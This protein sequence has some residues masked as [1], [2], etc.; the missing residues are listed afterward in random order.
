[1]NA[2][3]E[4]R[5][6]GNAAGSPG[7]KRP[8]TQYF[9]ES[10]LILVLLL[11]MFCLLAMILLQWSDLS[12]TTRV[13]PAS[14]LA[15]SAADYSGSRPTGQVRVIGLAILGDK[16]RD[17]GLQPGDLTLR[18]ASVTA[19]LILP[20]PSAT[21]I[22]S[23]TGLPNFTATPSVGKSPNPPVTNT[24]TSFPSTT[25]PPPAT[26]TPVPSQTNPPPTQTPLPSQTNPPPTATLPNPVPGP[27]RTTTPAPPPT[28]IPTSQPVPPPPQPPTKVP[29]HPPHTPKPH[30]PPDPPHPPHPPH[31]TKK[32]HK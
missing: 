1:M 4:R 6:E 3:P 22:L 29:P 7:E 27:T 31:P 2:N 12:Q 16:L 26:Q 23:L 9:R 28:N 8:L 30:K 24:R 20:V 11:G 19:E 5:L 17:A 10:C 13:L 14:V 18:L 21:A 25:Q 32:P 15:V